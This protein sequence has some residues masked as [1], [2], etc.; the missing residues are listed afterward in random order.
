[1]NLNFELEKNIGNERFR[2][3]CLGKGITFRKTRDRSDFMDVDMTVFFGRKGHEIG[4]S[5]LG[6][7]LQ[8]ARRTQAAVNLDACDTM[9]ERRSNVPF[10]KVRV[11]AVQS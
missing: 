11:L 10:V 9:R 3:V 5:G 2:R 1:M 6:D 4:G 7:D 8:I